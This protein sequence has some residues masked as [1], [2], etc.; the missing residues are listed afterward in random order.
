VTRSTVLGALAVVT[1][2]ACGGGARVVTGAGVAPSTTAPARGLP[3]LDT[4]A[5]AWRYPFGTAADPAAVAALRRAVAAGPG[6][7]LTV[8]TD[9]L[10]SWS[11]MVTGDHGDA[12]VQLDPAASRRTAVALWQAA[13]VDVDAMA[14]T[15]S[16][17]GRTVT[18][19][20]VLDGV[21]SPVATVVTLGADGQVVAASGQLA[22][23]RDAGMHDRIGTAAAI[24]RLRAGG[25][26][27]GSGLRPPVK[28]DPAPVGADPT[29]EPGGP[30]MAVGGGSC[31]SPPRRE[32]TVPDPILRALPA[33]VV[34]TGVSP[35][36]LLMPSARGADWLLP[37]YAITTS[38]GSNYTVLAVDAAPLLTTG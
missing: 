19:R 37:S 17:D 38:D 30:C 8:G 32:I 31:G 35:A 15:V 33:G 36:L 3:S 22:A 29:I 9:P 11:F 1:L 20:H 28:I 24:A 5:R 10:L 4:P 23:P 6:R 27:T 13:G 16:L 34:V 7:E 25:T 18:A 2:A 26:D 12:A 21:A 14:V